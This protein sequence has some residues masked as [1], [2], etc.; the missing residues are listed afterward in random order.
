MT[1]FDWCRN[2]FIICSKTVFEVL[3]MKGTVIY[4][5]PPAKSHRTAEENLGVG[6][7]ASYLRKK[8]IKVIIIDAWLGKI[9]HQKLYKKIDEIF[10]SND[11]LFIG[12]STYVSNIGSVSLIV[13][14]L[15]QNYNVPIVA[16]GFGPSFFTK[17]FLEIGVDIVA[18]GEGEITNLELCKLFCGEMTKE[19]VHSIA[20]LEKG[21][22]R[23]T[24]KN[25]LILD[26]DQLAFPARDTM[27][28]SIDRKSAVNILS[29]RGCMGHCSFCS[30]ISFQKL[31]KGKI[32]RARSINNFLDEIE[33]LYNLNVDFFKVIDDSFIEYP[34]DELWCRE[35]ADELEKR[36]IHCRFRGSIIT[37]YVSDGVIKELKRAGFFS[38]ACGIENFSPNVLLRYGKRASAEINRKALNIF[39]K[40]G[41]YVQCGLILFDPYTTME[42]LRINCAAMKEFQWVITK[43]VFT[44]L[45]AAKGTSF[46]NK[47]LLDFDSGDL[48]VS[49]ENYLYEIVDPAVRK[50]YYALKLWHQLHSMIYDFIIDPLTAPKNISKYAYKKLY[51][52]Y[53]N[54]HR[55]D[56]EIFQNLITLCDA[57]EPKEKMINYVKKSNY[58]YESVYVTAWNDAKNV[59]DS[60]HLYYDGNINKYLI[61][62]ME[63]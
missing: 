52:N 53:L 32:W 27:H 1:N 24:E 5:V 17:E 37:D 23:Y 10:I 13:T 30:V 55:V 62:K 2:Y 6:Y 38:F 21:T 14:Y 36:N 49:N 58:T 3:V 61:D 8:D 50:I 54:I 15:K 42:D 40:H 35:F 25:Q 43:G 16:G 20:Y 19:D 29:A 39:F 45:Y 34:R 18:I 28:Y 44:E 41:I 46:T 47:L 12:I 11:I 26:L 33:I 56:L 9:S 51:D 48:V 7:L 63:E 57:E 60:E 22:I 59:Y 31:S 4:I